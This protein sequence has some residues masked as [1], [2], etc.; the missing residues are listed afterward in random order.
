LTRG[1]RESG[2]DALALARR[3]L[4]E[5]VSVMIFPE[6]TRSQ[7]GDLGEFKRGAFELAIDAK[8]PIVPLVVHGARSAL[9]KHD[10]RLGVAEAEVHVLAPVATDGLTIDDVGTLRDRVRGLIA[11]ELERMLA[12]TPG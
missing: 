6:G 8:V 12:T 2:A 5:H 4:D 7:S 11:A 9:R 3:R 10:W 1:D